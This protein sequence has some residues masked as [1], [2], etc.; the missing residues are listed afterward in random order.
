[1]SFCCVRERLALFALVAL[2]TILFSP[3][4]LC[5]QAGEPRTF[6]IRDAKVVPV[7]SPPI[8]NATVVISR[9]VIT[10]VG[11]N[12]SIPPDAWVIEGKGLIVYPGLI[13]SFTDVGTCCERIH[14]RRKR[15]ARHLAWSRRSSCHN[16]LAQCRRRN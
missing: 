13:D 1:M 7:S 3:A 5:A 9:G 10:A 12:V 15:T 16:S 14:R 2:C 11:T 8:E 6:A 4:R